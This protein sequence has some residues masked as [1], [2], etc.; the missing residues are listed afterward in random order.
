MLEC[1]VKWENSKEIFMG[2]ISYIIHNRQNNDYNEEQMKDMRMDRLS[3]ILIKEIENRM[4][5]FWGMVY[6]SIW[7]STRNDALYVV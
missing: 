5:T 3:E 7:Q 6:S 1:S 4:P 2:A